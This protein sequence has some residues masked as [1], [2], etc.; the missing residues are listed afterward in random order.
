VIFT[1]CKNDG[2]GGFR[3]LFWLDLF[4][5]IDNTIRALKKGA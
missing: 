2:F 5:A 4:K 3:L 1:F